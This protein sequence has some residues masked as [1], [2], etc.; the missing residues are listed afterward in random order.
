MFRLLWEHQGTGVGVGLDQ[1]FPR[2]GDIIWAECGK[3]MEL[4]SIEPPMADSME[5]CNPREAGMREGEHG[6]EGGRV[7]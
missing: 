7:I 5:E 2:G 6:G 3:E 4:P 1:S